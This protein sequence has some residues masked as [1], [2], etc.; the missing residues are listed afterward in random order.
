MADDVTPTLREPPAGTASDDGGIRTVGEAVGEA[1]DAAPPV[2][3]A[4]P[5]KGI[6]EPAGRYAVASLLGR[7]GGGEVWAVEDRRLGRIM[8]VKVQASGSAGDACA[9]ER[10][11]AEARTTASLEHPNVLP[12]HDLGET[13]DGRLWFA[14]RQ[15]TGVT[16]AEAI[17]LA[18][19]GRVPEPIRDT[20]DRVQ[21]MI[22]VC[23]AV[24]YAHSRGVVHRDLKPANIMI[25]E[26]GE[27]L[28]LDWGS[29]ERSGAG[30]EAGVVG[31][32][33]YM[34]PEQARGE[35]ADGRSDV[36]ALGAT[37]WQLLCLRP[38]LLALGE[39][40][41]FW[42]RKRRGDIEE[43]PA[44]VAARI[45]SDLLAIARRALAPAP[46]ARF[47]NAAGMARALRLWL[48]GRDAA[49]I[50]DQ[51]ERTVAELERSGDH[52]AFIRVENEFRRA[53]ELD[54]ASQRA[55]DGL[56]RAQRGH[57]R[58]AIA[59]GDLTLAKE[60]LDT[61]QPAP[62]D[63]ADGVAAA[64]SRRRSMRISLYA[65]AAAAV[66]LAASLGW[67]AWREHRASLGAWQPLWYRD[68]TVAG[69]GADPSCLRTHE[70][71]GR[72]AGVEAQGP[73]G[74][75]LHEKNL[76]WLDG[77]TDRG[78]VRLTAE[79][80]W[81]HVVDGLV[82]Y[83]NA[84]RSEAI[85]KVDI[86]PGFG[87]HIGAFLGTR[88]FL[89]VNW[90]NERG[91]PFRFA[92]PALRPGIP[93]R[94]SL[95]HANGRLAIAID[96]TVI[97]DEPV[98]LPPRGPE[99]RS[100]ALRPWSDV[101]VRRLTVERLALPERPS[102]LLAGDTLLAG[103]SP[104]QAI[105]LFQQ[106][107][108]DHPG[109]A[110]AEDALARAV[111]AGCKS[112][113]P[114][115]WKEP[116]GRLERAFPSSP[117]LKPCLEAEAMTHWTAGALDQAVDLAGT[118]QRRFPDS[119]IAVDLLHRRPDPLP[120]AVLA[121]LLA[122]IRQTPG[123]EY[124]D[125]SALPVSDLGF[126]RGMHLRYLILHRTAVSDLSPLAGM[127]LVDLTARYAPLA[128]LT[129]LRGM[130]L[131]V[132]HLD[133]TRANDLSPL[134]GMPLRRFSAIDVP[135]VEGSLR[136]VSPVEL[137]LS[138]SGLGE[139]PD[140]GYNEMTTLDIRRTH[141]ADLARLRS[142]RR[143]VHVNLEYTAV[144]DISPLR[145]APL[146]RLSISRTHVRDV[147]SLAG[148]RL[149]FFDADDAPLTDVRAL[150]GMPL[151]TLRLD[152]TTVSDISMLD[153]SAIDWL[154]INGTRITDIAALR[155]MPLRGLAIARTAITDLDPV[156]GMTQLQN[157]TFTPAKDQERF[158]TA[159]VAKLQQEGRH[160]LARNIGQ[161][162]A[163][164][165]DD[166]ARMKAVAEPQQ[167]RL[168]F[169]TQTYV[170]AATARKT[171]RRL[172]A[173][174]PCLS[175]PADE[176]R[177]LA[178]LGPNWYRCWL[179]LDVDADGALV[180]EDGSKATWTRP[181]D[182]S[183]AAAG[184]WLAG[185][186]QQGIIWSRVAADGKETCNLVLEWDAPTP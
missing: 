63:L 60:I 59:S 86:V 131:Q 21:V 123:I 135:L 89:S 112:G 152:N 111:L 4:P 138:G 81:P 130:P 163:W 142:A 10:F 74:V 17:A 22:R 72:F 140:I 145:E 143:L 100:F 14:M 91:Q 107:A 13:A 90:P 73:D 109:G 125:L 103:D 160:E 47:A 45:P 141:I 57:I 50:C 159:L 106:V 151:R 5:L 15:A 1:A 176:A 184:A 153:L 7:G 96:G 173:R 35:P 20:A 104:L 169:D 127:P 34:S 75:L 19:E 92:A 113:A 58:H 84:R 164:A 122:L 182:P 43:P 97:I 117:L 30:G 88:T 116:L 139:L 177:L 61:M 51:A 56:A 136:D 134:A 80:V 93:Y 108:E 28:V 180:W 119:H 126:L 18:G 167:G 170:D 83:V 42:E 82:L 53:C 3:C 178:L 9:A 33:L 183:G 148:A 27:L 77:V 155:G 69:A 158:W 171:A 121:R 154:S 101:L 6:S 41:D 85:D 115:A 146:Q 144:V 181:A 12:V 8:A 118:L 2:L 71:T 67:W 70:M 78:D 76:F 120:E 11:A 94:L 79:V 162:L 156:L 87:G 40:E 150:A 44:G 175:G 124:L 132:L 49:V 32:P 137:H 95:T 68:F 26:F 98:V 31:T 128:D 36:Y 23:E 38:P 110:L 186:N 16:L 46:S 39:G 157:L 48:C 102:P 165:S 174:L 54:S 161:R 65:A 114:N 179:G 66:L 166:P 29:A 62:P 99:F 25:G 105:A 129:P 149:R 37:L 168:R 147:A 52:A 55:R 185:F 64:A 24:A 172:G 133:H